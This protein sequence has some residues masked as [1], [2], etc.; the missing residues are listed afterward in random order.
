MKP[1]IE[2]GTCIK[3]HGSW[4]AKGFRRVLD[5]YCRIVGKKLS[6]IFGTKVR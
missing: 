4:F 2:V 1:S 3:V 5:F 6:P